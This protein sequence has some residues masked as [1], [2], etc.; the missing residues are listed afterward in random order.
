MLQGLCTENGSQIRDKSCLLRISQVFRILPAAFHI[1]QDSSSFSYGIHY[2]NL[3]EQ[4]S[5]L[6]K[7]HVSISKKNLNPMYNT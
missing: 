6:N 5:N 2:L 7:L 4:C 3:S 1:F